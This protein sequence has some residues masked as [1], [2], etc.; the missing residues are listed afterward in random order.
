MVNVGIT[1]AYGKVWI[2][3]TDGTPDETTTWQPLTDE[4]VRRVVEGLEDALDRAQRTRRPTEGM[5]W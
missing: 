5:A 2:A 1:A 3:L 4:E